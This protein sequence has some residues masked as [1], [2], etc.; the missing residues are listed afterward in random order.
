MG[1]SRASGALLSTDNEPH[2][3]SLSPPDICRRE[4]PS[5]PDQLG[6][7]PPPR[8][9][10]LPPRRH[11]YADCVLA[12][13]AHGGTTHWRCSPLGRAALP[14]L[15]TT[16]GVTP[17]FEEA[18]RN[19]RRRRLRLTRF[20]PDSCRVVWDARGRRDKAIEDTK[21][22]KKENNETRDVGCTN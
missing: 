12:S 22:K 19:S 4:R 1:S 7:P 21:K 2:F 20:S 3:R 11:C 15:R 10:L 9:L 14:R 13:T 6:P 18:S 17:L 8:L 5:R 16:L